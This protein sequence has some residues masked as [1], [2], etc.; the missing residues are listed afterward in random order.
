[1]LFDRANSQIQKAI[2]NIVIAISCE[3]SPAVNENPQAALVN[4]SWLSATWLDFH[5][6]VA[7]DEMHQP[8]PLC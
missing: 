6:A 3:F 1:M 4:L 2:F 5:A 7:T 8:P